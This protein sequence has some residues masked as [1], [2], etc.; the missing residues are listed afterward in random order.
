[1]MVV[2]IDLQNERKQSLFRN[3]IIPELFD[4]LVFCVRLF[5]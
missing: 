4:S 2:Q 1:M 5:L 3:K